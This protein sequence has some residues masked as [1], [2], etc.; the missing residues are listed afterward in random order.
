MFNSKSVLLISYGASSSYL[1][2][3]NEMYE[4][5]MVVFYVGYFSHV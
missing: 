5:E 1:D 4:I 3:V 2:G